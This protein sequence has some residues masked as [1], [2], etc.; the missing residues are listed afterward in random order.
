MLINLVVGVEVLESCEEDFIEHMDAQMVSDALQ[1][2]TV[3]PVHIQMKVMKAAKRQEANDILFDYLMSNLTRSSLLAL[4]EVVKTAKGASEKMVALEEDM[5]LSLEQGVCSYSC[6]YA[7]VQQCAHV[8][9]RM[10]CVMCQAFMNE[11]RR[12]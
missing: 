2:K 12:S 8:Y 5:L 6:V 9:V 10:I 1:S 3:I 7:C 4:C 11:Q